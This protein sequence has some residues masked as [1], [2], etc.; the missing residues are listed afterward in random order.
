MSKAPKP[1]SQHAFS[2]E[3][4]ITVDEN[5]HKNLDE[6]GVMELVQMVLEGE[7][8]DGI[9]VE[10]FEVRD[11]DKTADAATGEYG[12]ASAFMSGARKAE[13]GERQPDM[14]KGKKR[15]RR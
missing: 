9:T 11:E 3:M 8:V 4:R 14:Q 2:G 10:K 13:S 7:H 5:I 12:F 1:K 6:Q 15:A